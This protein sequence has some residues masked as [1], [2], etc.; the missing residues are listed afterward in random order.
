MRNDARIIYFWFSRFLSLSLSLSRPGHI[1]LRTF[2][3]S[4]LLLV[5]NLFLF[6]ADGNRTSVQSGAVNTSL[7]KTSAHKWIT[8]LA[9]FESSDS[10]GRVTVKTGTRR[11]TPLGH[12]MIYHRTSRNREP[13]PYSHTEPRAR[14]VRYKIRPVL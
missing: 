6:F 7:F 4:I 8:P 9:R 11:S 5:F 14:D 13:P 3:N 12:A 2:T 1:V 10:F